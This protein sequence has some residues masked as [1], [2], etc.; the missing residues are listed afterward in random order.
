VQPSGRYN[1][2]P[3]SITGNFIPP[4][5]DLVFNIAPLVVEFDH[6]AFNVQ[7]SPAKPAQTMSHI[8]KSMA[9]IIED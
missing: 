9:P 8:I 5:S 3:P 7:F 2:V 1:A 6:L 4:K